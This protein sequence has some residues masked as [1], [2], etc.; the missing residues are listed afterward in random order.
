MHWHEAKLLGGTKPVDQMVADI[1]E[2]GNCLKVIPD[3]LIK[4]HLPMVCLSWASLGD[5]ARSFS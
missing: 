2:P 3:A 1:G 5:D 4:I